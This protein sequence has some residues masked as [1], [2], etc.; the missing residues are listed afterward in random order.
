MPEKFYCI[1]TFNMKATYVTLASCYNFVTKQQCLI[2][3]AIAETFCKNLLKSA[4][5]RFF[6]PQ[7]ELFW[8]VL[9]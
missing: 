8:S 9:S 1:L 6:K 3:I 5:L 7:N 2:V 4:I